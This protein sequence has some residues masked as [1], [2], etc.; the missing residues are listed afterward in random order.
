VRFIDKFQLNI[1]KTRYKANKK[2]VSLCALCASVR[3]Y[4]FFFRLSPNDDMIDLLCEAEMQSY[5]RKFGMS[6]AAGAFF[7]NYERQSGSE[8]RTQ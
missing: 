5:Y 1:P 2:R 3:K 6:K 7:R 8:R 4:S